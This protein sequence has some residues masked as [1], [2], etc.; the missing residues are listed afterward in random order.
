MPWQRG[1]QNQPDIKETAMPASSLPAQVNVRLATGEHRF[2]LA[3]APAM[4][5]DEARRWLDEQFT[6]LGC[7][8]LRP[9]GKLLTADKVLVIAQAAGAALFADAAWGQSFAQAAS[10]ALG[11]PV[12]RVDV[13]AMAVSY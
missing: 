12:V 6:Q 13:Q 7:E 1:G 2:D 11:K 5:P 8:P 3:S 4:P 9:T 10:A